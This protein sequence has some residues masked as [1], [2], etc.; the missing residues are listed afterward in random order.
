M[1]NAFIR[2]IVIAIISFSSHS[3]AS[4][5][6]DKGKVFVSFP[7]YV[8]KKQEWSFFWAIWTL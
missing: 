2:L 5:V 7:L 4:S 1:V 8:P 6:A 3:M